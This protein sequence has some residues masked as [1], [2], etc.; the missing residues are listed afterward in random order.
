MHTNEQNSPNLCAWQSYDT[1]KEN[2]DEGTSSIR[3][4]EHTDFGAFT[5][6]FV[7]DF[8]EADS[9]GLQV[10][11]V[12]AG[13]DFGSHSN[14]ESNEWCDVIFSQDVVETIKGDETATV[15]VNTGKFIG[16]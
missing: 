16:Y 14:N 15:I 8:G 2:Q 4:G 11:G 12:T 6:L 1:D 13:E 9:Q 5:F 3:L 10:K 7:N